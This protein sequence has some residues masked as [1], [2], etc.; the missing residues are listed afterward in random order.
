MQ[1]HKLYPSWLSL[2]QQI[3]SPSSYTQSSC[4]SVCVSLQALA[5]LWRVAHFVL[6]DF[7]NL[8]LQ[9]SAE[10]SSPLLGLNMAPAESLMVKKSH[11]PTAE[12]I[13]QKGSAAPKLRGDAASSPEQGMRHCAFPCNL[14]T[15]PYWQEIIPHPKISN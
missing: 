7:L 11:R 14:L 3:I 4:V 12:S 8:S 15:V 9:Q 13:H 2:S 5:R 1:R 6:S 10:T